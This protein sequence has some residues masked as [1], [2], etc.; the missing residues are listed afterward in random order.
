MYSWR[1]DLAPASTAAPDDLAAAGVGRQF[2]DQLQAEEWLGGF[3][4]DLADLGV[5]RVTLVDGDRVV[6]GPMDLS[7]D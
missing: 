6:Y 4:S 1:V 3:W 5:A 2:A 7:A